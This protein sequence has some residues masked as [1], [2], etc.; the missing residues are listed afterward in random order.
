MDFF[1]IK[2]RFLANWTLRDLSETAVS[3]AREAFAA[4]FTKH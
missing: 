2:E 1:E 3:G 4:Y